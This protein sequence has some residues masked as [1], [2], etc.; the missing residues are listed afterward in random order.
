MLG[1]RRPSEDPVALQSGESCRV[2]SGADATC[3]AE[4][5]KGLAPPELADEEEEEAEEEEEE[6]V[7]F[8]AGMKCL[9][10]SKKQSSHETAQ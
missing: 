9:E 6:K 3:E 4:R 10:H 5:G 7:L 8:L 2:E 1:E